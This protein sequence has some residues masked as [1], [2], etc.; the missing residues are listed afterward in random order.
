MTERNAGKDKRQEQSGQD[1]NLEHIDQS[2]D[3]MERHSAEVAQVEE[4]VQEDMRRWDREYKDA[5]LHS[6]PKPRKHQR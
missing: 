2:L 1:S 5:R 6:V 3:I 4:E